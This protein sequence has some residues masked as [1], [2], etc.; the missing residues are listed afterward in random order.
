MLY[1]LSVCVHFLDID[2]GHSRIRRVIVEEI[3]NIHVCPHIFANCDDAVDDN[4][5]A[6]SFVRNLAKKLPQLL[7]NRPE[8]GGCAG[9]T[10]D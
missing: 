4:A 1:R 7:Q 8:S 10:P 9:C 6:R 3:Q 2:T 5:C